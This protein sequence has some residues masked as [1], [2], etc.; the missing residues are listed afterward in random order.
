MKRYFFRISYDGTAYSGWQ[1]QDNAPTVQECLETNLSKLYGRKTPIVGCGRTDAGVHAADYFFHVDLEPSKN[2]LNDL[3]FKLNLMLPS[4]ICINDILEVH[5]E[6]H[7]RFDAV[8]R[9]YL[10][11]LS[12]VKDSFDYKYTYRYDQGGEISFELLQEAAEMIKNYKSFF[13]FCKS[14]SDVSNYDCFLTES[15]W[16]MKTPEKWTYHISANRFLRGMVR[17][18]VGMCI[19]VASSR[20]E[21]KDVVKALEEQSR[22]QRAW[23]VPAHGLFLTDIKYPY[24]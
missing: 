10:Y 9:S 3:K 22:M 1:R 4:D 19:N 23:T 5:D 24:I 11:H 16:I 2:H 6:A 7:A 21:L 17:L 12:F 8:S 20:L 15:K 13:P 14:K 18:I